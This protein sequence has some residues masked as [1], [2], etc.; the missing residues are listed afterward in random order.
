MSI[1]FFQKEKEIRDTLVG[2]ESRG[3]L[4]GDREREKKKEKRKEREREKKE[5]EIE[6]ERE[7][8]K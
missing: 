5:V 2:G 4:Y 8:K 7:R 6:R 3:V 1:V